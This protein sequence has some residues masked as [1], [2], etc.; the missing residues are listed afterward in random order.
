MQQRWSLQAA[1]K[2]LSRVVA[3]AM[4]EGPQVITQHGVDVAIVLS[5]RAYRELVT[6]RPTLSQFFGESPL[7]GVE[8]DLNRAAD[9]E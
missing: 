2:Q 5:M 4:A 9:T 7:H 6:T 3:D 1:T 8:L